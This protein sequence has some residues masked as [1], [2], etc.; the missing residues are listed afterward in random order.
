MGRD[1]QGHPNRS[2]GNGAGCE[3]RGAARRGGSGVAVDVSQAG[4]RVESRMKE[5]DYDLDYAHLDLRRR[6][7]LYRIGRG[8]QG[9]LVVEPYKSEI[10]PHWRF[11]TVDEARTSADAI[12]RLY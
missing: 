2:L 12:H 6:P 4:H 10:L 3:A 8:E 5:F 1:H 11:K 7:D 9:V